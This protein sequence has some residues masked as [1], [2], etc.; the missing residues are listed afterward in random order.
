MEPGKQD[1]SVYTPLK[2]PS[3]S[4]LTISWT[5]GCFYP[6][7]SS[8]GPT[9]Y[10]METAYKRWALAQ[11]PWKKIDVE[12]GDLEQE[13]WW[14]ESEIQVLYSHCLQIVFLSVFLNSTVDSFVR[15]LR[16]LCARTRNGY[17]NIL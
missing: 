2:M 12:N 11:N 4:N 13:S 17:L 5:A 14:C 15:Q 6:L 8:T 1:I 7:I 9:L 3:T 10:L 16:T